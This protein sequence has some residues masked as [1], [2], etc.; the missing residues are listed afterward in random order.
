MNNKVATTTNFKVTPQ[1][2]N[3]II[4]H[5]SQISI[6]TIVLMHNMSRLDNVHK[7]LLKM[8]IPL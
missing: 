8:W 3:L 5:V 7:I 4:N 6:R 1:S 2:D